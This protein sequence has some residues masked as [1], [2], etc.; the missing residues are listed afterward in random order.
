MG[1]S[2]YGD[3]NNNVRGGATSPRN[4]SNLP[5]IPEGA[6]LVLGRD[7]RI[8][9]AQCYNCQEWG[10]FADQCPEAKGNDEVRSST[11]NSIYTFLIIANIII[12][13]RIFSIPD[14]HTIQ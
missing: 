13:F 2:H 4:H 7:R 10:H 1:R 5:T 6:R 3:K 11:F 9:T 12:K 8:Y 14:L